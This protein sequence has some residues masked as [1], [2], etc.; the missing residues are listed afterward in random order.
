MNAFHNMMLPGISGGCYYFMFTH[1]FYY[2]GA[3]R[4]DLLYGLESKSRNSSWSDR[5]R[6]E[7]FIDVGLF[8]SIADEEDNYALL[9]RYLL[10]FTLSFETPKF[11]GRNFLI[12]YMGLGF[13]GIYIQE[14]GNGF[15]VSP[16][17][18]INVFS[19]PQWSLSMETALFL[20]TIAFDEF[21]GICPQINL[22]F[23]L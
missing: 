15:C 8:S 12:P 2:G 23:I 13:G 18:G 6:W 14:R 10:G 7:V 5:G 21:F 9:F 1:D 3:F 4:F 17:L 20:P 11:L 19:F 16:L 22:N